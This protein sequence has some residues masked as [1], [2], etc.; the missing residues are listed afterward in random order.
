MSNCFE[1]DIVKKASP[2]PGSPVEVDY[3]IE[4]SGKKFYIFGV[5]NKDKARLSAIALLEFYKADLSNYIGVIV[6]EAMEQ[7]SK[8][9][10]TYLTQ[11]ADKQFISLDAFR[12]T[13]RS[14]I[15]RC[16]A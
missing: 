9:Y 11:N 8:K 7:L 1:F 4:S 15:E 3:Q 13:G 12:D 2:L 10:Q 5:N 16:V 6:H 14:F